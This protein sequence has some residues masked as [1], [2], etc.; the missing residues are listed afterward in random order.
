MTHLRQALLQL[1]GCQVSLYSSDSPV[2][3]RLN[4]NKLVE[5]SPAYYGHSPWVQLLYH[6]IM[7]YMYL[8]GTDVLNFALLFFPFCPPSFQVCICNT[9]VPVRSVRAMLGQ[10]RFGP[11]VVFLMVSGQG[12]MSQSHVNICSVTSCCSTLRLHCFFV[13]P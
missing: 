12:H 10:F 3:L 13:L 6:S 1:Q 8:G 11:L 9:W 7:Y 2:E 4:L 5:S